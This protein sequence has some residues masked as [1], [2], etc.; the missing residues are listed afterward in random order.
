M[1]KN[2]KIQE[3]LHVG[4]EVFSNTGESMK[5]LRIDEDGVTTE[6]GFLPFSAHRKTWFLTK[7]GRALNKSKGCDRCF[8]VNVCGLDVCGECPHFVDAANVIVKSKEIE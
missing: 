7:I 1:A 5:I 2:K 8:H 3:A 6:Q 4:D